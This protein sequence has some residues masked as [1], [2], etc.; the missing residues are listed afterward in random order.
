VS[1]LAA[2]LPGGNNPFDY[3][4]KTGSLLDGPSLWPHNLLYNLMLVR[5][6]GARTVMRGCTLDGGGI[7]SNGGAGLGDFMDIYN[8]TIARAHED[9]MEFDAEG[10]VGLAVFNVT[11]SKCASNMWSVSPPAGIASRGPYWIFSCTC[12]EALVTFLK[13]GGT[14]SDGHSFKVITNN[15]LVQTR[16]AVTKGS[17]PNAFTEWCHQRFNGSHSGVVGKNNVFVAAPQTGD[18]RYVFYAEG[19]FT[20]QADRVN[21]WEN[22]YWYLNATGTPKQRWGDDPADIQN[23]LTSVSGEVTFTNNTVGGA[24][25]SG[26]VNPYPTGIAGGLNSSVTQKSVYVRGITC[27]AGNGSGS[28]VALSAL[29]IGPF[30]EILQG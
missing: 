28:P 20:V 16:T 2:T 12:E 25:I 26:T 7:L 8:S 17:S 30:A 21:L 14:G 5:N 29:P 23:A 4:H 27:L 10:G 13:F 9:T 18:I 15:A 11:F 6:D 1:A 19:A 22:N 24:S 3:E